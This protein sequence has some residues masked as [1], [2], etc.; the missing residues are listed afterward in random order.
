MGEEYIKRFLKPY[1]PEQTQNM[2]LI[3][4][5]AIQEAL[6]SLPDT[7]E[8]QAGLALLRA[9]SALALFETVKHTMSYEEFLLDLSHSGL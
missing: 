1:T 3:L 7:Q 9:G 4:A 2:M 6:Q 5:F 8:N